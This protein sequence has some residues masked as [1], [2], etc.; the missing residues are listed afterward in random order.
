M[1]FS[2]PSGSRGLQRAASTMLTASSRVATSSA[3]AHPA[4]LGH[5][6]RHSHVGS[7]PLYMPTST[8]LEILPFPPH[9]N[10]SR[11]LS[12]SLR[13]AKTAVIRGPQGETV[14]PLQDCIDLDLEAPKA[15]SADAATSTSGEDAEPTK[16]TLRV[17][18]ADVKAQRSFWGLTRALLANAIT[19]VSEGHSVALRLVGVGYR[20][21]V[22]PDPLP[23]T[24]KLQSALSSGRTFFLND[25]QK[26]WE[27][28]R[29]RRNEEAAAKAGPRMRL[30]IRLGYSHPV[31]LA[32]PYGIT[33]STPQPN[34]ILLRGADKEQLG[35]FASQIRSWRKPEPYKGK[36]V[37][38]GDE[39]IRLRTPKKK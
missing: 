38:V 27:I 15:A 35:L 1:A 30:N 25:A 36:G 12:T 20:A 24:S 6:V 10:P 29:L 21:S 33:A 4:M 37:F 7:A 22:E 13:Y 23:R 2:S 18:D 39:T 34:R 11:P 3:P 19:G 14:V 17:K 8:T 9:P 26:A 28:E 5:S 32:V 16:L 31:L